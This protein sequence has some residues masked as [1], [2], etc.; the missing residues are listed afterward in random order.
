M[1]SVTT[2]KHRKTASGS[3]WATCVLGIAMSMPC[4]SYAQLTGPPA[5]VPVPPVTTPS[6]ESKSATA[7]IAAAAT[8]YRIRL[9][10]GRNG[11]PVEHAHVRVWYDESGGGGY[12]LTTSA[13]GTTLM[14][15]PVGLPIRVLVSPEDKIDC[16]KFTAGD[17]A[18][19][20]NLQQ[21]AEK[22]VVL[23]NGC[24]PVSAKPHPG[25]LVYFVRAPRWYENINRP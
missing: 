16:R 6:P 25:E 21:I 11:L 3:V 22:G 15:E 24:G 20:Y 9:L 4:T 13:N 10:D 18:P 17:P 8:V 14:P 12:S 7:P 23:P 1:R 5:G 2:L 19:A